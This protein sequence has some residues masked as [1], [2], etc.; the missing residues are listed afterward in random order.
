VKISWLQ[1]DAFSI[2]KV[3]DYADLELFNCKCCYATKMGLIVSGYLLLH[4]NFATSYT[5]L[6]YLWHSSN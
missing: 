5:Q 1:E 6:K 3:V 4:H 2:G